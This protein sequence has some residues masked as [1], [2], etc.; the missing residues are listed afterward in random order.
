MARTFMDISFSGDQQSVDDAVRQ[1]LTAA[2]YREIPYGAEI[3]WKMGTG[4]MTAMHYI[5]VEYPAANTLRLAGWVQIGVGSV[6]GKERDLTG[7]T[8]I[9][10]KKSVKAT[11]EKV[12]AAVWSMEN[13]S[14]QDAVQ[15]ETTVLEYDAP[16]LQSY[17]PDVDLQDPTEEY[18]VPQEYMPD[19][20]LQ[21]PTEEYLPP[22]EYMPEI[23][24]QDPTE[25][26]PAPQ[27]Y[28]P[29]VDLQDPTEE[30]LPPQEYN[31]DTDRIDAPQGKQKLFCPSCGAHLQIQSGNKRFH[32]V[33]PKCN[34]DFFYQ[35]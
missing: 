14:Q 13:G 11:M 22:Q 17:M 25:A 35:P 7:F 9:I 5:K 26:Y 20:D 8:G 4:L 2:N 1:T 27:E 3:V 19:I 12:R 30:Y 16:P 21:D 6:G 10:P 18:P 34:H 15:P 24:L 23:D 31:P 29:D 32:V 28:M 33:C